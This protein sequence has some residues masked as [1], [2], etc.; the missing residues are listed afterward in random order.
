MPFWLQ[1]GG[2]DWLRPG[3]QWDGR[4]RGSNRRPARGRNCRQR[5]AV[6]AAATAHATGVSLTLVDDAG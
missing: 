1:V 2:N 6:R 3:R 4:T 5:P